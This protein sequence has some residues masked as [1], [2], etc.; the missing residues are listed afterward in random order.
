[1]VGTGTAPTP[2]RAPAV[3]IVVQNL[4]VPFDRRV[5]LECRALTAA[6]YK[7]SVVCPRGPGDPAEEEID[8]VTLYKYRPPRTGTGRV[9]FVR[10]YLYSF[11]ATAR[12]VV[13]ARVRRRFDVLQACNPPDIFW[14]LALAL[15][16][17]GVKFVFDHHDLCPE[18]YLSK[19]GGD[20][21][22]PYRGLLLL[23][24]CTFRTAHHVIS[25][26][27]SYREIAMARGGNRPDD[28]TVV[29]TGPDARRMAPRAARAELRRGR[30]HLCVY[31]G[32]MGVQDGVDLA[33]LAA[34]HLVN[35]LGRT[36]V[37]FSFVGAGEAFDE[38]VALRDRLGL[39]DFVDFPGRLPD[40]D[41]ADLLSTADV[42]L[43]PDPKNPLNDLSTMNKTMEYMS[44]GLPVVSFD[45]HETRI[46]AADA[47]V[48][49]TPNDVRA[50]AREIGGLLDDKP[51][52]RRMGAQGRR[53]VVDVLAWSHQ[54]PRY[55]G[56]YDVLTEYPR[57]PEVAGTL[58]PTRA[59]S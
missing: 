27:D 38:L 4:P 56:V 2:I 17:F 5:W 8:G 25:T 22:L 54:A 31:L 36:D 12:L 1:M 19:F 35:T 58:A 50:F 41:V 39:A 23:E 6:G 20:R 7:V 46:S 3:L 34:D 21:S 53:R 40:D 13:K 43:C 26:N 47:A 11:F 18:L 16:P 55:V 37:S 15:R 30:R 59:A 10:E 9:A 52:R 24:R 45:L 51:R 14:P 48:Y 32:V 33:V 29:R 42:G 28:V 57:R 44:Y 49:V